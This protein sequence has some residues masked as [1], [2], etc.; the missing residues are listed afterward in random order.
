MRDAD[1]FDLINAN[2]DYMDFDLAEK[3]E[4]KKEKESPDD[5]D[6]FFGLRPEDG[7]IKMRRTVAFNEHSD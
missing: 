4:E 5:I 7:S 3:I 1:Q 2:K 6:A